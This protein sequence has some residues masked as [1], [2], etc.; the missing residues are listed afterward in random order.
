MIF[1]HSLPL[2]QFFAAE[3]VSGWAGLSKVAFVRTDCGRKF[4]ATA[5]YLTEGSLASGGESTPTFLSPM[6]SACFKKI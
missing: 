4:Y 1:E 2:P 6:A 5:R 3:G